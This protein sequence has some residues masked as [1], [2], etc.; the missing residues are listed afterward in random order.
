MNVQNI[1]HQC[2]KQ[3]ICNYTVTPI[4]LN[5]TDFYNYCI[6]ILFSRIIDIGYFQ[7]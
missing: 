4:I 6:L 2:V 7:P 1:T 3:Y 5:T